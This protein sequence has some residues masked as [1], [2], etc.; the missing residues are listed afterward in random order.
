MKKFYLLSLL[1]LSINVYGQLEL[2]TEFV[3]NIG[4]GF[5]DEATIAL[6]QDDGKIIIA[7]DFT[8]YDG[9][10]REK[11][12]RL[13]ADGTLDTGFDPG[14]TFL[15]S[16]ITD[17][18]LDGS[19]NIFVS[20]T[21]DEMVVKLSSNG[22]IDN[23]FT[24]DKSDFNGPINAIAIDNNGKVLVGEGRDNIDNE[25][26]IGRYNTNGSKDVTFVQD[27][28][29]QSSFT[30]E[31]QISDIV[32]NNDGEI[33]VGGN[34]TQFTGMPTTQRNLVKLL[35]SDGLYDD[36]FSRTSL[37]GDTEEYRLNKLKLQDNGQLII[38]NFQKNFF[39]NA[40]R[41]RRYDSD[42]VAGSSFTFWQGSYFNFSLNGEN[43][44]LLS[45]NFPISDGT[46]G[47]TFSGMPAGFRMHRFNDF[48]HITSATINDYRIGSFKFSGSPDVKTSIYDSENG[49]IVLGNFTSYAG[50]AISGGITRFRLCN[51]I[52]IGENED[53][54][55]VC[56]GETA[57][58]S[59][60]AS[61]S[62]ELTYQ[63]KILVDD[64]YEDLIDDATY[65]GTTTETL[66]INAV[67]ASMNSNQYKCIIN[68]GNCDKSVTK[69]LSVLEPTVI[70]EQPQSASFCENAD[71]TFIAVVSGASGNGNQRI[72]QVDSLNGNGFQSF[73]THIANSAT[74]IL[75][76]V[77]L[78]MDGF[79]YRYV[80][81]A[82][83]EP[84]ISDEAILTVNPNPVITEFPNSVSVC[85][86]GDVIFSIATSDEDVSYQWQILNRETEVNDYQD[87]SDNATYS[88]TNTSELSITAISK[89]FP[90][91][92]GFYDTYFKCII[93][94]N[95]SGCTVES[96]RQLR[97]IDQ[98]L[99]R[100]RITAQPEDRVLCN[101]GNGV[102]TNFTITT[103][104][105]SG[106]S[107]QWQVDSTGTGFVDLEPN[108]KYGPNVKNN[109]LDLNSI[110]SA[111]NDFLYRAMILPCGEVSEIVQTNVN[112]RPNVTISEN[113]VVCL[114]SEVSF[115]VESD[116][117][118]VSYQWQFRDLGQSGSNFQ[119]ISDDAI[120]N[121]AN[122]SELNVLTDFA[123]NIPS[124]QNQLNYSYRCVV[125]SMNE[126]CTRNSPSANL[127]VYKDVT[128][129]NDGGTREI[130]ESSSASISL[131][132]QAF[133]IHQRK[134]QYAQ[135]G[136]D[137]FVD[138]EDN[139]F[140]SGTSS[141]NL[142]IDSAIV[143]FDSGLYRM[144]VRGC[145]TEF[146][147]DTTQLF[148]SKAPIVT[149]SP[150][151][152]IVC[153]EDG[154]VEFQAEAIGDNVVYIWQRSTE[155]EEGFSDYS[156]SSTQSSL[157]L[158]T[159][160]I[161]LSGSYFRCKIVN[162]QC[163]QE[164]YTSAAQL[165]INQ[166]EITGNI[167]VKDGII[168]Y[169]AG[170]TTYVTLETEGENLSY[171]W[172]IREGNFVDIN[173]NE[174]FSGSQTDTLSINITEGISSHEFRCIV[175][176]ECPE[177]TSQS[178]SI[179]IT[180]VPLPEIIVQS[181]N[182]DLILAS[183][184]SFNSYIWY[185]DGE[186]FSTQSTIL[187][188]EEGV[189]TLEGFINNCSNIS[190]PFEIDFE[191]GVLSITDFENETGISLFPN[192]IKNILNIDKGINKE[193][194]IQIMDVNG[195]QLF[196]SNLEKQQTE[197]DMAAYQQGVYFVIL[198]NQQ[199]QVVIK[200]II[201]RD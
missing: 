131:S 141:N 54:F 164:G 45:G 86:T 32:V 127:R 137:V 13:N 101:T 100:V 56:E 157:F 21:F 40:Y 196:S 103:D 136:T 119:D 177:K 176:G 30:N 87:L 166:V 41:I 35:G 50:E 46:S 15:G 108:N 116:Q 184:P 81:S 133:S 174:V 34:F 4:T 201:K 189:Y 142:T 96:S 175:S 144:I 138:L 173:D 179:G 105:V 71:A 158:S 117:E 94:N 2:D 129:T 12:L 143:A 84:V 161:S 82:C 65:A 47:L 151:N 69:T 118:D 22:S 172:Q 91:F 62:N 139:E 111:D 110:T 97:I 183:T 146:I 154:T 37:T 187:V 53:N 165:I 78:D 17:I 55:Q 3:N 67:D 153:K 182:P 77:K 75:S 8:A 186:E 159:Q 59:I 162:A 98:D 66:T 156:S 33:Y 20:G 199:Q 126:I 95:T 190:E 5:D 171:Q 107:I 160:D 194:N 68:D 181:N 155:M 132:A 6:L 48:Q 115:S 121:G 16:D 70:D 99:E 148:V 128:F 44:I 42:G 19:G 113:L 102:N 10:T 192:P 29:S 60:D 83:D 52:T 135:H 24:F 64:L 114:N 7:G 140:Y 63:W 145:E 193:I 152:Q 49:V 61:S 112:E 188:E 122:T 74:L 178:F 80:V 198:R 79:K 147:S 92:N 26:K 90:E 14:T 85:G 197:I 36:S 150:E 195:R 9:T 120:Y 18:D 25:S 191:G 38:I 185:K 130:C 57:S 58:Y 134:W 104:L 149:Q 89:D 76:N 23:S 200:K 123:N 170:D 88:G 72:W 27:Q 11:I 180:Q 1:F 28:F 163:G 93:T 106:E 124:S 169:C 109:R 125:S 168:D 43:P 73:P 31:T 39:G 51:T 167:T